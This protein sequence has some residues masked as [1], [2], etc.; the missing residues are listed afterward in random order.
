MSELIKTFVA[1]DTGVSRDAIDA[2]LPSGSEIQV[3]GLVDGLEES[4][5]MLQETPNDLLVIA[6]L[7][8][9][10]VVVDLDLQF[11]D[12]GLAFGLSPTRTVHDLVKSGGALDAEKID[13]YLATHPSG[14]R[15]LLAPTR[16]DH[17]G[18]V[19]ADFLREVYVSLR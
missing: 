6:E 14:V 3:V 12:V 2:L 7:G 17:A 11:G 19:S 4:W 9:K 15:A 13:A 10:V 8:H 16:P 1:V 5:A 18:G